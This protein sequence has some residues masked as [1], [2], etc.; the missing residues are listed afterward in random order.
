M[1]ID[2]VRKYCMQMPHTTEPL[3]WGDDLVFKI[4]G[5]IFA[6]LVLEPTRVWLSFKCTPE[7]FAELTERAGIIPAPYLA[8]YYWVALETYEALSPSELE[9]L[10]RD[11]YQMVLEKLPRKTRAA[12]AQAA[13][14]NA[15]I[16]S[17][18]KRRPRR[19]AR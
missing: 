15:K 10:L 12:L 17:T 7:E 6:V 2:W 14:S 5:K 11:S 13:P 18:N 3:Q 4:G 9:W 8:R 19:R 1:N 16:K